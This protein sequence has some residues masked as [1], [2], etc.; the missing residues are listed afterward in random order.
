MTRHDFAQACVRA[1]PDLHFGIG[2][3]VFSDFNYEDS[4]ID[5][6]LRQEW[7]GELDLIAWILLDILKTI[8][9]TPD[10]FIDDEDW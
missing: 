10:P 5:F 1:H 7:K 6:C 2:H 8:P 9:F 3:I 4:H